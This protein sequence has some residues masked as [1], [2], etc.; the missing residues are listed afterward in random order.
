MELIQWR[1]R[2]RP[3]GGVETK[4]CHIGDVVIRDWLVSIIVIHSKL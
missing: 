1:F 4:A 3:I 2:I